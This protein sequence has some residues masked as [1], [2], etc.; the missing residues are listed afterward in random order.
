MTRST[1]IKVALAGNP[2]SGKSSV[3][4]KLTGLNQKVGNYPGVTVDKKV[5]KLKLPGGTKA[6]VLDLPGTYSIYPKSEEEQVVWDVLTQPENPDKPDVVVVVADAT[7]LKRNLL[8]FTQIVDLGHPTVLLLNMIDVVARRNRVIEAEVL[9][10]RLGVPVIRTNARDGTGIKEL[11]TSIEEGIEPPVD[12]FFS[13]NGSLNNGTEGSRRREILDRYSKI[14][15]LLDGVIHDPEEVYSGYTKKLD[16]LFTH[17]IWGYLLFVGILLV[18]FQAIFKWAEAPMEW[19]DTGFGLLANYL[20]STLPPG[21]LTDLLT[22]GIIPGLAGIMIFIPQIAILFAVISLLEES[23]YMSRVVFLMD[24][25]MRKVGLNGRSVVPLV[26]GIACAVPAIMATRSIASK[27]DRLITIL[28]T[29]L[30]SCSARLPVYAILIAMVIPDQSWGF[31]NLQ[32]LTLF[33]LY[34]L[35]FFA[36][37]T[38]AWVIKIFV[39]SSE[40]SYLVMEMP[41]YKVPR[42]RNMGLTVYEKTKTFVFEAGKI[43]MAISIVLWIAATYGPA[44]KMEQAVIQAEEMAIENNYGP[45]EVENAVAAARLENSFAGHFGKFIEPTIEPLG[46]DW[47]IGIALISSFAA[48]EVFVGTIATIYSVGNTDDELTVKNRLEK[49]INPKTGQPRFNLAVGISLLLFYAFAMQC[50]S[51]L[52]VVYRETKGWKWP[53][54]QFVFMFVLAYMSS[55]AAYQLLS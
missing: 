52:A 1:P 25:L 31:F 40:K 13:Y 21:I 16:K 15:K 30:M 39:K 19:I 7:N 14:D 5:A 54:I 8:L 26:S 33:G 41:S 11:L 34:F 50:M 24:K 38:A 37:I 51:T 28:V 55:F 29:P 6:E 45:E 3:F 42:W 4:N 35:G 18:V 27:K 17:K 49:E 53:V 46:Y 36:A 23:G 43:I 44:E 22:G 9:A 20:S 47:K 10:K 32:G 12:H 48:R 2:N